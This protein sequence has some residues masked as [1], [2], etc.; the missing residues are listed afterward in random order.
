MD[1]LIHKIIEIDRDAEER[2]RLAKEEEEKIISGAYAEEK[3]LRKE[4]LDSSEERIRIRDEEE[5][6]RTEE[7]LA[8]LERE[9]GAEI[10]ALEKQ[11]EEKRAALKQEFFRSIV[12]DL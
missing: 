2:L 12:G 9:A 1:N 10:S 3:R 8:L 7:K 5:N 4:I 11:S 6:K